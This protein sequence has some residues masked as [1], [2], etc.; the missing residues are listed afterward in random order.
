M[1]TV[2][3]KYLLGKENPIREM[4]LI[5]TNADIQ[6]A[7]DNKIIGVLHLEGMRKAILKDK[8]VLN[9][10]GGYTPMLG[11]WSFVKEEKRYLVKWEID[12]YATSPEE[13]IAKAI[14]AMPVPAN[15]ETLAT[16]FDVIEYNENGKH[17]LQ[18]DTLELEGE[19]ELKFIR[20]FN[21]NWKKSE[22]KV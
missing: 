16:V 10:K 19:E 20:I 22:S 1:K 3:V 15:E 9:E 5:E 17:H 11:V 13:A 14:L 7:L 18:I 12:E 6:E 8:V 2:K 4:F 21:D